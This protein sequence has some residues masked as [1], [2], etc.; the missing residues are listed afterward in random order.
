M[1]PVLSNWDTLAKT[2]PI[3]NVIYLF[4]QNLKKI[5]F[6][7]STYFGFVLYAFPTVCW[8]F[9]KVDVSSGDSYI[10]LAVFFQEKTLNALINYRIAFKYY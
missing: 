3:I 7:Q 4:L 5:K 9:L 1:D 10:H 8:L 2:V 6:F